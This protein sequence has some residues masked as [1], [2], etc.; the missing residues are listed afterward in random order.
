MAGRVNKYCCQDSSRADVDIEVE[1]GAKKLALQEPRGGERLLRKE[2]PD[3]VST[4]QGID[5]FP[6]ESFK[7][8]YK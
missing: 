2:L 7:L 3:S 1:E 4:A 5:K 8:Y 6:I